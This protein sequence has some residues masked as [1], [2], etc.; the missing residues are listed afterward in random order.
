MDVAELQQSTEF[1][2]VLGPSFRGWVPTV[3]GRLS[4]SVLGRT[5]T[6]QKAYFENVADSECRRLVI[7]Q[8]RDTGDAVLPLPKIERNFLFI[9]VAETTHFQKHENLSG[10][11]YIVRKKNWRVAKQKIEVFQDCLRTAAEEI[12]SGSIKSMSATIVAPQKA[13][14]DELD[15]I[16]I[17]KAHIKMSRSGTTDIR[18]DPITKHKE[19]VTFPT[20][21]FL[22]ERMFRAISAQ[23]FYF[24]K[25]IS[26]H[27]QHHHKTTDTIT[28]IYPISSPNDDTEWR[29]STLYS[30]YR[31]VIE[32]KRRPEKDTFN[33]CLGLLAY[34]D[35][36][37][38]ISESEHKF[39]QVLPVYY[40]EEV[41][42]SIIAT[43]SKFERRIEEN[44]Y[45]E[46][47]RKNFFI[48][49][50]GIII[51]YIG[52]MQ[53]TGTTS[54]IASPLLKPFLDYLLENPIKCA[55]AFGMLLYI[56]VWGQVHSLFKAE[57]ILLR[58]FAATHKNVTLS[59]F[60][61]AFI[62]LF[63]L[64]WVQIILFF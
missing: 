31:K 44:R 2:I 35:S 53:F 13:L 24:I 3:T 30:M 21:E 16:S 11:A 6:P 7:F 52:L 49:A 56:D 54:Q 4:F 12:T 58:L 41:S 46:D 61:L 34:A 45:F 10:I 48:A 57:T 17:F 63:L 50:F 42:K 28:D 1:D 18:Y 47:K 64:L 29:A 62:V 38:K 14:L 40:S 55:V 39:S 23:V 37:R 43:Q 25:D 60:V 32:Y 5:T 20:D 8:S 22:K 9:L 36:F 15:H 27:H 26:H 59:I 19:P 33:D 51:A